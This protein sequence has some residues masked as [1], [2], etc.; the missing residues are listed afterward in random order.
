MAILKYSPFTDFETF[1]SVRAFEDTMNRLFAGQLA[2]APANQRPWVPAVDIRET[3]QE[4]VL[5]ADVPDMKFED[6]NVQ[7][8]NGTLTIKGERKFEQE[9]HEGGWHRLERSYGTFERAFAVP[10]SIDPEKV[11]ADY[12]NGVLTVI[13]PK[14]EIAKPRQVKVEISNN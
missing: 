3:D 13:L 6:M 8:E 2:N 7:L 11:K 12:K 1:P 4:I 5:K 14:K 9:K 10:E